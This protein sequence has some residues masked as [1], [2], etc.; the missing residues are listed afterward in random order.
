M[1]TGTV[2]R[3]PVYQDDPTRKRGFF[4]VKGEDGVDYFAHASGMQQTSKRFAEVVEG[5]R[6]EFTPIEGDKGPRAIEIRVL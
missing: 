2:I 1:A 5:D 3:I 6:V 4:F